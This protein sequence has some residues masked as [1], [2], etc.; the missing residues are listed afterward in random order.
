MFRKEVRTGA[1]R[2]LRSA[3]EGVRDL[4]KKLGGKAKQEPE[5]RF[6]A[7]YDKVYRSDVLAESWRRVRENGG[8]PGVDGESIEAIEERGVEEFLLEIQRELK[9]GTYRPRPVRREYIPKPDGRKRPLG[10]PCV[11]DRV[12]QQSVLLVIEPIFEA[13][14]KDTSWGF[15]PGRGA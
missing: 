5:F 6:Y 9:T 12:V 4:R 11:R 2:E 1:L 8:A 10:I 3:G 13:D 15:R 7:L 14:F